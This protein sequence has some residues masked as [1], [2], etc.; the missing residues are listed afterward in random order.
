MYI[1]P[2]CKDTLVKSVGEYSCSSCGVNWKIEKSIPKFSNSEVLYSVFDHDI[3]EKVTQLAEEESWNKAVDQ[4]SYSLGKYTK[5]YIKNESRADWHVV[6]PINRDSV[7]LDIGSGW[8]NIAISLA[9][10]CKKIYCCDVNMINLRLL[11]ARIRDSNAEN[12]EVFQYDPNRFLRLPFEDQSFDTVALNGVLEWMGNVDL[13]ASPEK[14]QKEALKEIYRVLKPKGFLYIGIENRYSL[15]TLRGAGLHG[16]LPF[17]GLFPR[18]ISNILTKIIRGASHRTYIYSLRG[19]RKL[20]SGAGF[21][22]VDFYWPYPSYHD[23]YY[24]IPLKYG[25]VK[26]YWLDEIMVS[27]STKFRL[28]RLLGLGYL[29]FHWLAFSYSIRCRK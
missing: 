8:G 18:W 3:A 28:A 22:G 5:N 19:Y 4:Y 17:V 29:P 16:E 2:E 24:L 7:L 9:Q 1:C 10:R 14:I 15:S 26:K 11:R 23:P 12:I 21:N 27:R 25:W 13:P 6:L 20:I